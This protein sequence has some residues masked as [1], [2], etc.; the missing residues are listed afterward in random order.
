MRES[1]ETHVEQYADALVED[2]GV[3]DAVISADM[4]NCYPDTIHSGLVTRFA[5]GSAILHLA[6]ARVVFSIARAVARADRKWM[7][8]GSHVVRQAGYASITDPHDTCKELRGIVHSSL[9]C[10]NNVIPSPRAYVA[11]HGMLNASHAHRCDF[12]HFNAKTVKAPG[13]RFRIDQKASAEGR[14]VGTRSTR[15]TMSDISR[16]LKKSVVGCKL[17]KAALIV[18]ILKSMGQ[19][20]DTFANSVEAA[21]DL[22]YSIDAIQVAEGPMSLKR[23]SSVTSRQDCLALGARNVYGSAVTRLDI[24]MNYCSTQYDHTLVNPMLIAHTLKMCAISASVLVG[25][26]GYTYESIMWS[27]A[28]AADVPYHYNVHPSAFVCDTD[29]EFAPTPRNKDV[30]HVPTLGDLERDTVAAGL[31]W[32]VTTGGISNPPEVKPVA[33]Y[34]VR[35]EKPDVGTCR[36][37]RALV[38]V[39]RAAP[40]TSHGKNLVMSSI[41]RTRMAELL[42]GSRVDVERCIWG[43]TPANIPCPP[44]FIDKIVS[45]ANVVL[46]VAIPHLNTVLNHYT[47]SN[48]YTDKNPAE[49]HQALCTCDGD[50]K[51][52][53]KAAYDGIVGKSDDAYASS[54]RGLVV[55]KN[56]A[57]YNEKE[58][59]RVLNLRNGTLVKRYRK[60]LSESR[61]AR[62]ASYYQGRLVA[63]VVFSYTREGLSLPNG[64]RIREHYAVTSGLSPEV[65]S[66]LIPEHVSRN[67]PVS[68]N[69]R[70]ART[71]TGLGWVHDR[72]AEGY[73]KEVGYMDGDWTEMQDR[74]FAIGANEMDNTEGTKVW[75]WHL[76]NPK[77]K[78]VEEVQA[79]AAAALL[80]TV[81]NLFDSDSDDMGFL[82][83]AYNSS[84]DED[85]VG[86]S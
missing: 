81:G 69:A 44:S 16:T 17:V 20:T 5:S 73:Y 80:A 65:I 4:A 47:R 77:V 49:I 59:V 74:V 14:R 27:V 19:S 76:S 83:G 38:P 18:Q 34:K 53:V 33:V 12:V 67:T 39:R 68:V 3:I 40:T 50:K 86:L 55:V 29:R 36:P 37:T 43:D 61:H 64:A 71:E 52:I 8:K 7:E 58:R 51:A 32:G 2:G 84:S 10:V 42:Q 45:D 72:F 70:I 63:R 82:D 78:V 21:W 15:V 57:A 46:G 48:K 26:E 22:D 28:P 24:Y 9:I 56:P 62:E 66:G 1:G 23:A 30:F 11:Y 85:S 13:R 60:L 6:P 31:G 35:V 75:K 25:L 79:G 41:V 54:Q